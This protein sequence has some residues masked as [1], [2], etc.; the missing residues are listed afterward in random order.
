[1]FQDKKIQ[2]KKNQNLFDTEKNYSLAVRA[3]KFTGKAL[4]IEHKKILRNKYE[5][6][7]I[8]DQ[9][10][11]NIRIIH[12]AQFFIKEYCSKVEPLRN[13]LKNAL[14]V[15]FKKKLCS[16]CLDKI[17]R[18]WNNEISEEEIKA[19][20]FFSNKCC[21]IFQE[22]NNIQEKENISLLK[23]NTKEINSLNK[24]PK[25]QKVTSQKTLYQILLEKNLNWCRY[26]GT[27]EGVSWRPGPWGKN[28]LCNKHGC[29]YKGYGFSRGIPRLDLSSFNNEKIEQRVFPILQEF[30]SVCYLNS[31]FEKNILV[32]CFG[33]EKSYHQ[34][35]YETGIN[36]DVL[37]K[38]GWFC[39]PEC[40]LNIEKNKNEAKLP[41]KHLL[42][43]SNTP[44][45]YSGFV[46]RKKQKSEILFLDKKEKKI[47][48]ITKKKIKKP[49]ENSFFVSDNKTY[50]E[51]SEILTPDWVENNNRP[52]LEE[53]QTDNEE[54]IISDEHYLKLHKI[55]EE[56]EKGGRLLRPA[57]LE[58]IKKEE[59]KFF[60]NENLLL[61]N[62]RIL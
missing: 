7:K 42:P 38:E 36:D 17:K 51:K 30:C 37:L 54:E 39:S 23:V 19:I 55:Y 56:K 43:F 3:I 47:K 28:T 50:V 13:S 1:M 57:I 12:D 14:F 61:N 34:K 9:K 24:K 15:I 45:T 33:C 52:F 60:Q 59:E 18:K 62:F 6:E 16:K 53:P 31:S 8:L 58:E 4:G 49:S 48:I 2:S 22:K 11:W 35:C 26:C 10:R 21:K 25:N 44:K 20:S 41:S 27:T 32:S 29:D 5:I 46:L 40:R